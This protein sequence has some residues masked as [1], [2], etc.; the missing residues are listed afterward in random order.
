MKAFIYQGGLQSTEEAIKV[1]LP[2][3]G[4]PFAVDQ[5]LNLERIVDYGAGIKLDFNK[6]TRDILFKALKEV[7]FDPK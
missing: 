1:E 3:I 4:F 7:I 5:D 6:V 2:V